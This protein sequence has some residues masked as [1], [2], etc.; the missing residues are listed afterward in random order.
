MKIENLISDV[1][2]RVQPYLQRGQLAASVSLD[3]A[4]NANGVV[5]DGVLTLC[6]TQR[7]AGRALVD[8]AQQRLER[9]RVDG[10]KAVISAPLSY[11]PEGRETLGQALEQ[12]RTVIDQTGDKLATIARRGYLRVSETLQGEAPKRR[13]PRRT[14]K[15]AA[16][17]AQASAAPAEATPTEAAVS[18]PA[19]P[20]DTLQ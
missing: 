20:S 1:R 14:R 8:E 11:L 7:A 5:S 16:S 9:A 12:S 19:P 2:S 17:A 4:R 15:A 6:K 10:L 3:L 18:E 13:A